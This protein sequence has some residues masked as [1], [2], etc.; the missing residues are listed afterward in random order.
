[1]T[2]CSDHLRPAGKRAEQGWKRKILAAAVLAALPL[3]TG[4]ANSVKQSHEISNLS[5][6]LDRPVV[7]SGRPD[8]DSLVNA[9][10]D[11][12]LSE[13]DWKV[14]ESLGPKAIW[15]RIASMSKSAKETRNRVTA[16]ASTRP[17]SLAKS[18]STRPTL[19]LEEVA[20]S[21][22]AVTLPD[23]KIRMIYELRN[24]GGTNVTATT[25]SGTSRRIVTAKA[26]D[27]TPLVTALAAQLGDGSTVAPL[28]NENTLI[29]T[30]APQMK[31][32]VLS[33]L[34]QLDQP[35]RQ[36]EITAKMFEVSHDF[37]FQYGC[38]ILLNRVAADGTQSA[39]S[40]FSTK[41]FANSVAQNG[42]TPVSAEGSVLKLMQVFQDAGL[43]I[44]ATF[45]LMAETGLITV[46]ASPRMTVAAGQTGYMLAGS[47]LPIQSTT[48]S[49]NTTS[50][51]TTYK[52]VG[53]QL[54]ITPQSLGP[55]TVKLHA[56]TVVS[57]VSGFVPLPTITGD[58]TMTGDS[59]K[60]LVNPILDSREAET[61]VTIED[62]HT[63]VFGGLR[64]IRTTSRESKVPALGD[65]PGL[66]WLF[67]NHRSQKQQ[68]DLYFFVTPTLL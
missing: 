37:D 42:T 63:L 49:A 58:D 41:Q 24:Y 62:G 60:L 11:E 43:S 51:S 14:L 2:N 21:T 25:D 13:A 5:P 32:S 52:P 67:K 40:S 66:G 28:P 16:G 30:C 18:A 33:M 26:P 1:M 48:I 34:T 68:T 7:I 31:D 20:A 12:Q 55:D 27:L 39:L 3:V 8:H 29:I 50:T 53:V 46:V 61:T 56:I 36:V 45:Q 35:P 64:M 19:T 23:G 44:D 54:Y 15:D 6:A 57:S 38:Q 10:V 22:P 59:T 9:A 17:G 47:E 65:I 4:C